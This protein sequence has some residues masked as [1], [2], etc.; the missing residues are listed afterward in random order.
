MRRLFAPLDAA[1]A[2][3]PARCEGCGRCC[4][5]SAGGFL[6]FAS[7][8][9][10]AWL[11]TRATPLSVRPGRCPFQSAGR[12]AVRPWRPL[13]CRLYFCR[14]GTSA[15]QYEIYERFQQRL[16]QIARRFG[17]GWRYG[18]FLELIADP[19]RLI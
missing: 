6:L 2:R 5:F 10:V 12:C 18:P 19:T 4:D 14:L 1:V 8:V 3:W 17:I 7:S 9:E 11:R 15:P 16:V 13:G